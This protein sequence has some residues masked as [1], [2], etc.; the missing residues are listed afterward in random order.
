[1]MTDTTKRT[2]TRLIPASKVEGEAVFNPSGEKLGKIDDIYID[3]TSG[4]AEFATMSFGGFLGAGEKHHPLPWKVLDYDP[5][6]GGFVVDLDK[7]FLE[8]SPAY[9]DEELYGSDTGWTDRVTGY[10]E[11]GPTI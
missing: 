1:M 7:E 3:K 2:D 4:K 11:A 5:G 6:R 8:K 9:S 10:Y